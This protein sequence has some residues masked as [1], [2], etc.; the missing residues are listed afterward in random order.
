[1]EESTRGIHEPSM[2]NR[3]QGMATWFPMLVRIFLAR[4]ALLCFDNG[5]LHRNE[6]LADDK[7]SILWNDDSTVR[8]D[9]SIPCDNNIARDH[10]TLVRQPQTNYYQAR[11]LVCTREGD[12]ADKKRATESVKTLSPL[13]SYASA[14]QI[15]AWRLQKVIF[16]FRREAVLTSEP[17]EVMSPETVKPGKEY[18][19]IFK[20]VSFFQDSRGRWFRIQGTAFAIS[21]YDALTAAHNVWDPE[22]GPAK[23]VAL[24][25]DQRG[26]ANDEYARECVAAA[27]HVRWSELSLRSNDFAMVSVAQSFSPQVRIHRYRTTPENTEASDAMGYALGFPYDFPENFEGKHLIRSNGKIYYN[28]GGNQ[29][30]IV[31]MANTEKGN[32]GG[33]LFNINTV[34][35][36]VHVGYTSHP[37]SASTAPSSTHNGVSSWNQNHRP[38]EPGKGTA[39][40]PWT[41]E[42]LAVPL[43]R[44]GNQVSSFLAVQDFMRTQKLPGESLNHLG[45]RKHDDTQIVLHHFG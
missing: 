28:G 21:D 26:D 19:G 38:C 33:P 45:Q 36:G 31:H 6:N 27:V 39:A 18:S 34:A 42:N 10:G 16:P 25:M 8:S 23:M 13:S 43:N 11:A 41:I 22:F 9:G 24:L 44:N 30:L 20:L 1:M 5:F 12:I 3:L 14:A 2:L 35:I 7:N 17:R 29:C 32:S 4:L 15:V 40:E 37:K